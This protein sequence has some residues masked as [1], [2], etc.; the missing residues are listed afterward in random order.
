MFAGE[1]LA[2]SQRRR[3]SSTLK[4]Q[5]DSVATGQ[6]RGPGRVSLRDE[7]VVLAVRKQDSHAQ[8]DSVAVNVVGCFH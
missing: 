4:P 2:T 6:G 5:T 3:R 8:F 7:G 1:L